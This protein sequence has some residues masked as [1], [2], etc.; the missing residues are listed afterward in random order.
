MEYRRNN[1]AYK[2]LLY[3]K[4]KEEITAFC[5]ND[6]SEFLLKKAEYIFSGY[7]PM[8]NVLPVFRYP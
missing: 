7:D 1:F 4:K 6:E 5:S 3:I 2:M 8:M